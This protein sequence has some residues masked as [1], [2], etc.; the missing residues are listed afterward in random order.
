MQTA[1]SQGCSP[2][3]PVREV[4]VAEDQNVKEIDGRP[5]V[6]VFKEDIGDVL[7]RDLSRCAGY[8]FAA[9]CVGESDLRDYTVRTIIAT[10]QQSGVLALA[11]TVRAG[12]KIMF[13]R[14]DPRTAVEDMR[15]MLDQLKAR[16]GGKPPRGGIYVSCAARGPN[17]FTAP[18]RETQLIAACLGHFPLAGFFANGEFKRDR[19]YA[20]TGVLTL[21][22]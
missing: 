15:R 22:A 20:Y 14:R 1:L 17:Q 7:A 16:L 12:D 19:V 18:E 2:I 5:A 10:D 8:I 4:T 21:F 13:C 11:T 9:L 3:G 6:Q